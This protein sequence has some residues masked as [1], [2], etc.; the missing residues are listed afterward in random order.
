MH[1]YVRVRGR[2]ACSCARAWVRIVQFFP[3]GADK[4]AEDYNGGREAQDFVDFIN[5]KADTQRVLGGGLAPTAGR[6]PAF[7]K[8]A[9]SFVAA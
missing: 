7:D 8:L 1:V 2:E 4:E 9:K 6:L 5:E 3:R